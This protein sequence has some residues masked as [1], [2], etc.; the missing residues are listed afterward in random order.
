MSYILAKTLFSALK[1]LPRDASLKLGEGLGS[2]FWHGGY[3]REVILTNLEMAFPFTDT[4]WKKK[5]GKLSL[6]NIGRTLTEFPKIPDYVK[7]GYIDEIFRF[8]EGREL[9][10]RE[11]GKILITAHIGNWEIGGAGLSRE[12]GQVY[13]L[14]YRMK[15]KKLNRL[16]TQIRESAGAKIIFHDQPLKDFVK[17]LKNGKTIVFLADQNALRHRGVFVDFFGHKAS[18]VSFPAKLSLKYGVPVLFGYQYYHYETKTYRAVVREVP[19]PEKGSYDDM[20]IQLV[21]NYTKKI[22]EAVREH[23]DQYFW[24][25]KRWKTRPEGEPENIY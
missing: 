2:L 11:G 5:I 20:V 9:L 17:A 19:Q 12:V 8:E 24:V 1:L 22:E 10:H 14:A 15:N 6:Q 21:Q 13:T 4:E 25:H 18:T 16:I 3:R 23:P 7:T